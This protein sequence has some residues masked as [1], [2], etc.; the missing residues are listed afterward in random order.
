M[1]NTIRYHNK[2]F[3]K[4]L[5][6]IIP[7]QTHSNMH[8]QSDKT[9]VNINFLIIII[10]IIFS[11]IK[12]SQTRFAR[13]VLYPQHGIIKYPTYNMKLEVLSYYCYTAIISSDIGPYIY[14][15]SADLRSML[16]NF[17]TKTTLAR[18]KFSFRQTRPSASAE[19]TFDWTDCNTVGISVSALC[20][21]IRTPITQLES[22][23]LI[24]YTL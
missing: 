20:M 15:Y 3:D 7:Q 22:G 21:R 12:S 1:Y 11:S 17:S 23:S 5:Y 13:A 16:I 6:F 18:P 14:L 19:S 10:I 4:S 24:I 9:F 2:S 8:A